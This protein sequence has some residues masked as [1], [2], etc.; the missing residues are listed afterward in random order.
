MGAIRTFLRRLLAEKSGAVA[1]EY[2]LIAA[3]IVLAM[4]GGLAALGGGTGGMWTDLRD[5]VANAM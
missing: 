4:M 5:T 2:G 1:I 3:L